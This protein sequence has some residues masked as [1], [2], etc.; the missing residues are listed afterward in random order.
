M[1]DI[2]QQLTIEEGDE[3][4]GYCK[5]VVRAH[6]SF[7][8]NERYDYVQVDR[9]GIGQALMFFK[10]KLLNGKDD[11]DEIVELCLLKWI[12]T[13]SV[14]HA[15]GLQALK[16]SCNIEIIAV[17]SI[18]RPI[19]V[20]PDFSTAYTS[21]DGSESYGRYLKNH[22][23]NRFEWSLGTGRLLSIEEEDFVDWE[24][25]KDITKRVLQDMFIMRE[26]DLSDETDEDYIDEEDSDFDA[27]R[28]L[29]IDM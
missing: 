27:R 14:A 7:F 29:P 25:D 19:H 28:G 16:P 9:G 8:G 11:Q 24:E 26:D 3:D 18:L 5:S 2:Y 21:E 4:G 1:I 17:D 23:V 10:V 20:V 13:A 15:S 22:D 12:K 6:P